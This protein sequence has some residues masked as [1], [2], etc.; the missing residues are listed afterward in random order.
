MVLSSGSSCFALEPRDI[1]AI[2]AGPVVLHPRFQMAEQYNDNVFY[3]NNKQDDFLTILTPSLDA[4]LGK[5]DA[6]YN[7]DLN[8]AFSGILYAKNPVYNATDHDVSLNG[9]YHAARLRV[10]GAAGFQL[11]DSIYGGLEAYANG[12]YGVA[13]Q[14]LSRILPTANGTVTYDLTEKVSTYVEGTYQATEFLKE[15]LL[16]NLGTLYNN[17]QW[18]GYWGFEYKPREKVGIF[19]EA[20]YGQSASDP[21]ISYFPKPAYFTSIGGY[22]GVRGNFTSKLSGTAKV[23]YDN[24]FESTVSSEGP[25]ASVSMTE[26]FSEKLNATLG[27]TR[28]IGLPVYIT[29]GG[30]SIAPYTSDSLNATLTATMGARHPVR[31]SLTGSYAIN[32]YDRVQGSTVPTYSSDYFTVGLNANY[33]I[34]S[35]AAAGAAYQYSKLSSGSNYGYDINMVTMNITIGY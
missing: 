22:L 12:Y 6:D 21:T 19:G 17:N 2:S 13:L 14:N 23:G 1:L 25:V 15:V 28:Q 4:R 7:V 27:Y 8:Y 31:L 29:Y 34:V 9:F 11:L 20:Y 32:S 16:P 26:Q 35:W 24:T 5:P 3:S 33:Q 10:E 18:K 30:G